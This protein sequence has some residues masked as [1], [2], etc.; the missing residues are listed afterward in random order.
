MMSG[1]ASDRMILAALAAAFAA[2]PAQARELRASDVHERNYPTVQ[3]VAY[4][5]RLIHE[6]TGGDF[7]VEI[8]PHGAPGSDNYALL[9]LRNGTLDMARVNVSRFENIVPSAA[10]PALPFLFSSTAHMRRVLDGP[11]GDEILSDL[12]RAGFIGLAFYDNGPRSFFTSGKP[13]RSAAEL[14][15]M[16]VRVQQADLW[17]TM[18]RLLGATA[19]ALPYSQSHNALKTGLVDVGENNLPSYVCDHDYEAAKYYSLTEHSMEPGVLVFSK[20]VWDRLSKK[21]QSIIRAAARQ[22][23]TYSHRLW[24]EREAAARKA[25]QDTGAQIV[26]DVDKTSFSDALAPVYTTFAADLKLL[27]LI[28]RIRTPDRQ[29]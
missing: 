2:A 22:S 9:Q 27:D 18:M 24:D 26:T 1:R 19:I 5:G 8:L 29:I 3:T 25:L 12:E 28:S 21:D 11:I 17:T 10:V 13:I 6:R 7:S 4:M 14:K 23:V 15:G 20:R 16:R